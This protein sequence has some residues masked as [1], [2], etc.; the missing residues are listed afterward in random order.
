MFADLDL[1][2][3]VN[4][5]AIIVGA[6]IAVGYVLL[7][8]RIDKKA[9]AEQVWQQEHAAQKER[10][11]RLQREKDEIGMRLE[12]ALRQIARLE[13]RPDIAGVQRLM[14]TQADAGRHLAEGILQALN[15]HDQRA[16]EGI[17]ELSQEIKILV[18]VL[19]HRARRFRHG[20]DEA[21][22][23]PDVG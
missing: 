6:M 7:R 2:S 14:E 3:T 11:D 18:R 19:E 9:T 1:T 4:A 22:D 21:G 23:P 16:M 8:W 17:R 5:G 10:A 20:D 15:L 13:E 12:E